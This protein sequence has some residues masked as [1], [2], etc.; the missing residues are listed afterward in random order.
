MHRSIIRVAVPAL[1]GIAALATAGPAAAVKYPPPGNPGTVKG[2][3]KGN[4]TAWACKKGKPGK[5]TFRKIQKAVNFAK[6]GDTVRVCKGV[7]KENVTITGH[8]K[9]G[10]KLIGNAGHPRRYVIDVKGLSAGRSQNAVQIEG[11]DG[12]TVRGL[13]VRHY[14]GNGVFALNVTGYNI[15]HVVAGFGGTYGIYAFNSKGGSISYSEGFYNTDSGFYI[16]QTPPQTRPRRSTVSHVKSWGNVLGFS[17]T[18]M[19][20]VTIKQSKWWNNG[21]GIVPNTLKS[22]RFPPETDNVI[23]DNDI[24]WNNYDYYKGSPFKR[25]NTSTGDIAYP[26]GVGVL[27]FGGRR[28]VISKNRIFGNYQAGAGMIPQVILASDKEKKYRDAAPLKGNEIRGNHYGAGGADLNGRD[29]FYDGSGSGNCISETGTQNDLPANHSTWANCPF[30]GT[31][32]FSQDTQSQ[33]LAQAVD[34]NHEAAWVKHPHKARKGYK[35]LEKC[36]VTKNGCKG[37]PVTQ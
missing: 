17:G 12:V 24:F 13:Y 11:A 28:N 34:P 8:K 25:K 29:V 22:E 3:P 32:A 14:K 10:L 15:N 19:R 4:L 5:Y 35:P 23:T 2:H 37:Q 7:W 33:L 26:V 9:D 30:G 6:R 27:L 16:G 18:N 21:T 20:Y 31:N 36:T 1:A